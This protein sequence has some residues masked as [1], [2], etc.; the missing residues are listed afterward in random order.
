M[1]VC[2]GTPGRAGRW[3]AATARNPRTLPLLPLQNHSTL[4]PIAGMN[5]KG[6]GGTPPLKGAQ[7][8][9]S[10]CLPDSKRQAQWHL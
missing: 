3:H 7:P 2:P 1:A 5:W 9:P 8:M 4:L 10:D 6:R